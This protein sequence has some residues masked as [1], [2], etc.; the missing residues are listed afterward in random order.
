MAKMNGFLQGLYDAAK[1]LPDENG[2]PKF[3]EQKL[4]RELNSNKKLGARNKVIFEQTEPKFNRCPRYNP[5]VI[6]D[7]CMNKASHL[8]V[9]CQTC[10]IPICLHTF[11]NR[12]N[13]IKRKN[14]IEFVSKETMEYIEEL[15]KEVNENL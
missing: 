3:D 14:F 8:Y 4:R 1:G 2:I 15:S 11:E 6:C 13:M 12:N 5:C 10:G 9:A 7:K